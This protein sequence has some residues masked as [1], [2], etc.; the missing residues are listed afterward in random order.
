MKR[1]SGELS[2][3]FNK[4]H[5]LEVEICQQ[6]ERMEFKIYIAMDELC[7]KLQDACRAANINDIENILK[8]VQANYPDMYEKAQKRVSLDLNLIK[9]NFKEEIEKE[10]QRPVDQ[11]CFSGMIEIA[12]SMLTINHNVNKI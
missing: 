6:L 11:M 3:L 5:A 2:E 10:I 9:H 4:S 8:E 1:L 7:D 12:I